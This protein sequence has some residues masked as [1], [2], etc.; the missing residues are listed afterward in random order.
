MNEPPMDRP[1]AYVPLNGIATGA[2]NALCTMVVTLSS[3]ARA[4]E[5]EDGAVAALVTACIETV[6]RKIRA[7]HDAGVEIAPVPSFIAS[8]ALSERSRLDTL[9]T[10]GLTAHDTAA[11]RAAERLLQ[12]TLSHLSMTL[13]DDPRAETLKRD[14]AMRMV[15]A[16]LQLNAQIIAIRSA[17]ADPAFCDTVGDG[18]KQFA[19]VLKGL[20]GAT[21][22][23]DL[24]QL[25]PLIGIPN[26]LLSR[27]I[28]IDVVRKR[29]ERDPLNP[30][31][32]FLMAQLLMR[33]VGVSALIRA[34]RVTT[35]HGAAVLVGKG[36]RIALDVL[37]GPQ[38]DPILICLYRAAT[39]ASRRLA[40]EPAN[41]AVLLVLAASL[42]YIGTIHPDAAVRGAM[43]ERALRSYVAVLARTKEA[44]YASDACCGIATIYR[45][46]GR[47]E[48]V[49]RYDALHRRLKR[50]ARRRLRSK[51][52][53]SIFDVGTAK[54]R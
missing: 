38:P 42:H 37:D 2:M 51:I 29:I 43:L 52:D 53:V 36:L 12:L 34:A 20:S 27:W 47:A 24:L 1:G 46:A 8:S 31:L 13:P 26:E 16:A 39:L 6:G 4:R 15:N 50:L 21:R 19:E 11:L 30:F 28:G 48:L 18:R 40:A 54:L 25:V 3:E 32:Q 9:A 7:V 5:L 17:L 10:D 44:H 35:G 49:P 23:R 22:V 14:L 45:D 33:K 41:D